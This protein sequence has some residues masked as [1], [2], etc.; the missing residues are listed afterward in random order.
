[1]IVQQAPQS[2]RYQRPV[3]CNCYSTVIRAVDARYDIR[4]YLLAELVM[5][6]LKNRA[7]VPLVRRAYY[8]RFV[9]PEAL[10]Y[11]EHFTARLLFGPGGR[12]SPHEYHYIASAGSY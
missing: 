3:Y 10:T 2:A 7:T 9:Q 11:L 12:F 8:E 6:C 4:G 1:M 5:L